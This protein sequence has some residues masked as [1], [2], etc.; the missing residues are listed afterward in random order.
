[1]EHIFQQIEES[2]E[3][4]IVT[5]AGSPALIFRPIEQP[6]DRKAS[7]GL[8]VEEVFVD[9]RG[10]IGFHEDPTTSTTDDWEDV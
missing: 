7:Q 2:S 1:M 9:Y 8:T 4:M 6:D 3:V 5:N 10:K